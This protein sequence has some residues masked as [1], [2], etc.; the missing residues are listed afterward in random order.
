MG[1]V[2]WS[3]PIPRVQNTIMA[4]NR[5]NVWF[6][7][8][9]GGQSA[10]KVVFELYTDIVPKTAENFRA[11]C[12]GEKGV[13]NAGKPLHYKGSSFHRVIKSFMIQGGDFTAGNGTGGES[14]YGEKF[15]DEAF[16]VK[17]EKPGVKIAFYFAVQTGGSFDINYAVYGPAKEPGKERVV[18]E[19]EKERQGDFFFPANEAGEYRF[20]FDNNMSTVSD[21]LVDF[22][23]AVENEVRSSLPQKAGATP[24]QLSGVEETIL[25]L[26]GQVSTLVRQQKYFRTRE[27]RN[28]STVRSTEGRIF[29]FS[30]LESGLMVAMAA[31]QVFIVK[32]F[33]TGGRKGYV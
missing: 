22:E 20:C 8:S 11:L 7:S 19:G 12:T 33:F 28:F 30:L 26:S 17:H 6:D 27:N 15:E 13:G 14:I 29:R 5:P 2:I 4:P 1:T 31:L 9:I 21:K 3:R 32:M 25:K 18:L 16:D 24:E 23:I 10:G